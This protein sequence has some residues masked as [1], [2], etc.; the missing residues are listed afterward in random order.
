MSQ[1]LITAGQ[2]RSRALVAL[3]DQ[4][5]TAFN[6]LT[7]PTGVTLKAQRPIA[8][9]Y[10]RGTVI[11]GRFSPGVIYRDDI[12]SLNKLGISA[13]GVAPT[14][15]D[16]GAG[17]LVG[18]HIVYYSY[19]HKSGSTLVHQ[20]NLS[21]GSTATA[22]LVNRQLTVSALPTAAPATD[23]RV[24]H[25]R[26]WGS[27]DGDL[28]KFI[29]DLDFA[30][31]LGSGGTYVYNIARG[32]T[33]PP[34]NVDGTLNEL[35]RGIPP[36]CLA[37]IT[38]AG[39]VWYL[40]DP[41]FPQ[42]IWHSLVNEPESVD[43]TD[44]YLDTTDLEAITG[45]GVQD[46]SLIIFGSSVMYRVSAQL[47]SLGTE[48]TMKKI[49][50]SVGCISHASIVNINH[51]L[52][53]AAEDG[54]A[55]YDGTPRKMMLEISKYWAADYKANLLRYRNAIGKN[56]PGKG[57]YRLLIPAMNIGETSFSYVGFYKGVDPALEGGQ[58]QPAW[59][60]H[61]RNA[62]DYTLGDLY[63]SGDDGSELYVG[64]ADG[65][66]RRENVDTNANDDGDTYLKKL[67]IRTG[68]K[69]FF[70][71]FG[72]RQHGSALKDLTIYLKSLV[73]SWVVRLYGGSDAA[74]TAAAPTWGPYT[75]GPTLPTGGV[76]ET[77]KFIR[78]TK[79]S[80]EGVT[81]EIQVESPVGFEYR[82]TSFN[83]A[84]GGRYVGRT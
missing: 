11:N 53:F 46:N 18:I 48:F 29:V 67:T 84:R 65:W 52:W 37:T 13:P 72:G 3:E 66:L 49:S 50:F 26:L 45:A 2:V 24:T 59:A 32:T 34:L 12:S 44:Q 55:M 76:D 1:L 63:A 36:Y 40:R 38:W 58:S 41:N 81:L 10:R 27:I 9:K 75:F 54:V 17:T 35:A 82:G 62:M 79:V 31:L 6:L 8:A 23:P 15:A 4:P 83:A 21:P 64:G 70:T 80:G 47:T 61:R 22:V 60:A 33:T 74:R 25:V 7:L 42:R 14:V 71:L 77:A 73:N 19:V 20:G 16:S 68:H 57:A 39:R 28:P 78:P 69:L 51:R 56:M 30:T 43:L 5:T